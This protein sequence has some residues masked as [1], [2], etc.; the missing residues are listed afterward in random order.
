[1]ITVRSVDRDVTVGIGVSED[2]GAGLVVV[3][4]RSRGGGSVGYFAEMSP[5]KRFWLTVE[6]LGGVHALLRRPEDHG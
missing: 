1:M 3:S 6:L 5:A 4:V 2:D